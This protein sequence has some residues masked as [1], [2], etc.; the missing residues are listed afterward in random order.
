MSEYD[1]NSRVDEILRKIRQER[2]EIS[3][4]PKDRISS[5]RTSSD[6]PSASQSEES[7]QDRI[8]RIREQIGALKKE[9]AKLEVQEP[10][11]PEPV[12]VVETEPQ[13][14][15][16]PE[17][18]PE[19]VIVP[20]PEP[21]PAT[22]ST[23]R[24]DEIIAS[25]REKTEELDPVKADDLLGE[26]MKDA[27]ARESVVQVP[28]EERAVVP[29]EPVI[30]FDDTVDV[31][32]YLEPE[33]ET[34]PE[35][36]AVP[37]EAPAQDD[38]TFVTQT[39]TEQMEKIED[40]DMGS[41]SS[42]DLVSA[43]SD[44][45]VPDDKGIDELLME[46]TDYQSFMKEKTQEI[47][48]VEE[49]PEAPAVME[50]IDVEEYV[51]DEGGETLAAEPSAE[52]NPVSD[53]PFE[54]DA[55]SVGDSSFQQSKGVSYET[56]SI[57]KA[58]TVDDSEIAGIDNINKDMLA[59]SI[60]R[61]TDVFDKV[62]TGPEDETTTKDIEI[63]DKRD[64]SEHPIFKEKYEPEVIVPAES[65]TQIDNI[66]VIVPD[67]AAPINELNAEAAAVAAEGVLNV[68]TNAED[69]SFKKFFGNT[70]I[71]DGEP[72]KERLRRAAKK[73][74][75]DEEEE[76]EIPEEREQRAGGEYSDSEFEVPDQTE[77]FSDLFEHEQSVTT[78]RMIITFINAVI[79]TYFNLTAE[80][81]R[82]LPEAFSS[83]PRIFA[84]VNAVLLLVTIVINYRSVFA[85]FAKLI[86]FKADAR[87]VTSF[88]AL[89]AFAET[90]VGV[91][92]DSDVVRP[93]AACVVAFALAFAALG[94]RLTAKR[95]FSNFKA[96]SGEYEKYATTVMPD[97]L[98][99]RRI[100]REFRDSENQVLLKRKT[101]FTDGFVEYARSEDIENKKISLP[102]SIIF[103]AALVCGGIQIIKKAPVADIISTIAVAAAFGAPFSS[104]LA[105]AL[106]MYGMQSKLSK[107][108]S[109][110]PGFKAVD[111]ITSANCVLLE[112][113]EI[114][115]KG[116]VMLHGIK[117][118]E[119]E[120]IDKAILYAAS[121]LINSC[122]TL[123]HVFM[124]VI[125]GKTEM[126][127]NVDSVVYEDGLGFSFWVD[128]NRVL[129]GSRKLLENH[130][131]EIP[132]RD[133]E[134]RYTKRSTR[135]AIYL[136]V[137]GKLYAMFVVSY[138][139]NAE[140]Q[141]SLS[142][143]AREGINIVV[144]SR[145]FNVTADRISKMY[146]IPRST[147][148]VVSESDMIE[149]GKQTNFVAH[150]KSA[151]THIG[152]M[153]SYVDGIVGC[154]NVKQSLRFATLLELVSMIVGILLAVALTIWGA[155]MTTGI[156]KI[157]IFHF[158][159]LLVT[160]VITLVRR[161]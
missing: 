98:F 36:A 76:E 5:I 47:P 113:H 19:P 44:I 140:V 61:G 118:F 4:D 37:A 40:V 123:S 11:R 109:T 129:L 35:I 155:I 17:P 58:L 52:A 73:Q 27:P 8:A 144:R 23:D 126:L 34:E 74:A 20:E 13:P 108:G 46:G 116:N 60:E 107:I 141:K 7:L 121:V 86:T 111:D 148:T 64:V 67:N 146:D 30:K 137:S 75:E 41:V 12:A 45:A 24:A 89:A 142:G 2:G 68:E 114:F 26:L 72:I 124:N 48:D 16:V 125:Q 110:V 103:L 130:E 57:L 100:T 136:A 161:Y 131:I 25:V 158:C 84:A 65:S 78:M 63:E 39:I 1:T 43:I 79:L 105:S 145:D 91:I 70:V 66:E 133:Y 32:S 29:S 54:S 149:L 3:S 95:N 6:I 80:F 9:A 120:R 119:K 135:D 77:F 81:N 154:Y 104:T 102:T 115:P 87:S 132:S 22:V 93:Y 10:A 127:Y 139:P 94:D 28:P 55:F 85:G 69:K 49:V 92:S 15:P 122:D 97:R 134:N 101:G 90:I 143:F 71:M 31:I 21:E 112:A 50:S 99:T 56:R 33:K 14:Q 42:E 106:P 156:A 160:T 117:T 51:P 128:K 159:W 59:P 83:N 152:T 151:M 153:S 147:I 138:R 88:A 62:E 53:D 38:M 82:F 157:L 150:A 18:A 96:I